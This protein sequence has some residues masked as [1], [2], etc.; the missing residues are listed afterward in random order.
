MSKVRSLRVLG[1]RVNQRGDWLFVRLETDAGQ[2]GYGEVSHSGDDRAV[3]RLLTERVAPFLVGRALDTVGT[4]AGALERELVSSPASLRVRRT[5]LSGAEHALWDVFARQLDV[6]VHALL[7][8]A[9]RSTVPL[10]AN[11]NRAIV[12]RSPQGFA[13]AANRAVSDGFRSVKIAPF[14][15]LSWQEGAPYEQERL[16]SLGIARTEAVRAAIGSGVGLMVDCHGRFNRALALEVSRRLEP[17]NVAWLED[18][19][20]RA[21]DPSALAA[22]APL[23]SQP[24]AGGEEELERRGIWQLLASSSVSTILPDVKHVGGLAEA[25]RIAELAEVARVWVA[26][27]NPAGPIAT[28]VSAELACTLPNLSHLEFAWGEADFRGALLDPPERV[29]DG[30]LELPSGPGFGVTLNEEV[31][32]RHGFDP[33]TKV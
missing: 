24:L 28:R 30:Q 19:I 7:G 23:I 9:L 3:A 33:T 12:D 8:G 13:I 27:H 26:P 11:V 1:V 5:A 21:D 2:V 17:F 18:L 22:I 25:K 31:L 14:D 29:V 4:L 15:G 16:L 6:P 20:W 32:S 10:Y